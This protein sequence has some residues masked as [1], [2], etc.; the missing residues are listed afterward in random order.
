[1]HGG[2]QEYVHR[3]GRT[4][5]IGNEGLATSFYNDRNE[6]IAEDLV[7]ILL[8]TKQELPDFLQGRVDA[9]I[10]LKFDD[11]TDES[12]AG[13]EEAD[14]NGAQADDPPLEMEEWNAGGNA[15]DTANANAAAED[16][17]W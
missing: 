3:I 10:E 7:K 16:V 1:M 15:K 9:D 13:D 6:D 2:V 17:A 12:V 4:A 11:S 14:K 8:E 5:R